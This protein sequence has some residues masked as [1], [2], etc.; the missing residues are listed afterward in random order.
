M[1]H[2]FLPAAEAEY[3][4]LLEYH[5]RMRKGYGARFEKAVFRLVELI[6]RNPQGFSMA[7]RCQG[8]REIRVVK[9]GRFNY[10]LYHEVLASEVVTIAIQHAKRKSSGWRK[11]NPV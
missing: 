1:S 2:R 6:E 11:R 5:E 4:A 10:L 8:D 7:P 3:F 9:I